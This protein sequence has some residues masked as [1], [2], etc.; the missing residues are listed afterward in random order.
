[1]AKQILK[2]IWEEV[3]KMPRVL[4]VSAKTTVSKEEATNMIR[5][6]AQELYEKSGRKPGRDMENWLEAERLVN[7]Q[8][9]RTC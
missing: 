1:M 9:K 3:I 8:L 5:K 2:E 7:A 4:K 6:K